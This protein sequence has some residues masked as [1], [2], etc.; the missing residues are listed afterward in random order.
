MT[1]LSQQGNF[2]QLQTQPESLTSLKSGS[3]TSPRPDSPKHDPAKQF[4]RKQDQFKYDRLQQD[5]DLPQL[6]ELP[7]ILEQPP[8]PQVL[9]EIVPKVMQQLGNPEL[10]KRINPQFTSQQLLNPALMAQSQQTFNPQF[11]S[12][13]PLNPHMMTQSQQPPNPQFMSQQPLN[14]HF[15]SQQPLNPHFMSQQPLNPQ[16]MSQQPLNSQPMSRYGQQRFTNNYSTLIKH[17]YNVRITDL[18]AIKYR[19]QQIYPRMDVGFE[20]DMHQQNNLR[21]QIRH[22][23]NDGHIN[24]EEWNFNIEWGQNNEWNVKRVGD[25]MERLMAKEF[26][27]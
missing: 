1:E 20:I 9:Q 11:M 18:Q 26:V 23:I 5:Q 12:Q 6:T 25:F 3:T 4:Q 8:N 19:L 2:S 14:P 10:Q 13:Q 17:P 21:V 24:A 22:L 16:F 15:M 7:Q 27:L